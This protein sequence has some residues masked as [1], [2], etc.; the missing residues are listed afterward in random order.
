MSDFL[1]LAILLCALTGA[2]AFGV[3]SAYAILRFG[4]SLMQSAAPRAVEPE[5]EMAG[6][7][8]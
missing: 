1:D 6:S 4:F 5:P 7:L 8:R 3:L 2:L